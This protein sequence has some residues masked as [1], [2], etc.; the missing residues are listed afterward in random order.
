MCGFAPG[1][2]FRA[3]GHLVW[4]IASAYEIT[5]AR[6]EQEMIGIRPWM[7]TDIFEI[8][9]TSGAEHLPRSQSEGLLMLRTLLQERFKLS[10][11]RE[12]RDLPTYVLVMNRRDHRLGAGL[13]PTSVECSRWIT[14]GRRGAPP[15]SEEL[16]CYRQVISANT[17]KWAAFPLSHLADVLTPRVGRP[18]R[19]AT[20]LAGYFDVDLN[21]AV[22]S[23]DDGLSTT[24]VFT[25]L[26]EQLGLK[27]ES[28]KGPVDVLVI[29]HVEHPTED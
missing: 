25:A 4:L 13:R 8:N 19:D 26:E 29:D 11:H 15:S 3:F 16:P 24:S 21:W 23:R 28:S 18:V 7:W 17:I 22:E 2:R 5:P 10:I 6:A 14:D 1:G 12:T 27:L 9:A 20:R